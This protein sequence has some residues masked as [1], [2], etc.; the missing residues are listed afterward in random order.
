M[1]SFW[2]RQWPQVPFDEIRKRGRLLVID[3]Q[4]FPYETLFSRDGYNV[5]VWRDV[6]KLTDLDDG[7]YDL[8]LLDLQGVGRRD[9]AEQGFGILKYLRRR[10]PALLIVAY[11]NAD[12]GLRY[13]EFFKLA[14]AV[15][16][17][18]ADYVEFKAKVDDLLRERFSLGFYVSKV[19]DEAAGYEPDP[20]HLS[21]L[22][23]A[24]ILK[25]KPRKLRAHLETILPRDSA[26]TVDRILSIVRS[27]VGILEV[28]SR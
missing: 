18:S 3:D 25:G 13:Q 16:P 23:Q 28:W 19:L 12:W 10:S 14:D 20:A 17:K 9:S 26:V 27:A 24:A 4:E 11:S 8:V 15:L 22:T 2:R 6:E 21:A 5:N 1:F 7:K